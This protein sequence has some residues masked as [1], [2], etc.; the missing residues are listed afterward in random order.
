[1]KLRE[2]PAAIAR[3]AE[4]VNSLDQQVAEL[5]QEMSHLE[6]KAELVAAFETNLKNDTQRKARRFE[7]LDASPDYQ[8]LQHQLIRLMNE[9]SNA[10]AH[11][12]YL[13]NQFSAAKLE[14]RW[15]IAEKLLG[16]EVREL[17]GL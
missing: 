7:I 13:R 2:Y 12:E 9:R 8:A 15:A 16:L 5:K 17:V 10:I 14:T 11:L 6:G 3:A 1:M 4:A